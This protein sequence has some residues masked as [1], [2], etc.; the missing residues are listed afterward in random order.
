MRLCKKK[1]FTA[2]SG[3]CTLFSRQRLTVC[4]CNNPWR[5]SH[6]SFGPQKRRSRL[7]RFSLISNLFL[8]LPS[9]TPQMEIQRKLVVNSIPT[10]EHRKC[11]GI[12]RYRGLS[13]SSHWP[14]WHAVFAWWLCWLAR[15]L[16]CILILND[17]PLSHPLSYSWLGKME[18]QV[19]QT[20]DHYFLD[21]VGWRTLARDS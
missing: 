19:G 20:E 1:R 17:E 18:K 11:F 16:T 21:K 8:S 13:I 14:W 10:R 9:T 7:V 6:F 3:T 4:A 15:V 5:R 2:L 12:S